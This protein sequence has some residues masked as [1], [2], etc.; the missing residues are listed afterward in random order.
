MQQIFINENCISDNVC[1]V[2]GEDFKHLAKAVRIRVGEKIRVTSS[3]EESYICE[4][5]EV[6]RDEILAEIR[7]EAFSTELPNKIYLFQAIPKGTRFETVIEKTVELGVYEIIPVEMKNCVVRWEEA[8]KKKKVERLQKIA[9]SAA[10]QSKR[11]LIPV[12]HDVMS[13]RDAVA[14]ARDIADIKL[15]PYES[16]ECLN[17]TKDVLSEI[18]PGQNISIFI[19]PEGGFSDEEVEIAKEDMEIITLGNRILRTDTAAITAL[20]LTAFYCGI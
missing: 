12:V 11:S 6:G 20:S 14:Y 13:Y 18:K 19:G 7:E 8:K 9:E 15:F 16:A 3:S 4:V 2:T 5:T 10:K 1:H 17:H